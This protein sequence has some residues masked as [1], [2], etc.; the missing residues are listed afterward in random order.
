MTELIVRSR[1]LDLLARC[2]AEE[3]QLGAELEAAQ[4]ALRQVEDAYIEAGRR[5]R[6]IEFEHRRLEALAHAIDVPP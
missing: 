4:Q 1:I 2:V 5:R 3:V 6:Q